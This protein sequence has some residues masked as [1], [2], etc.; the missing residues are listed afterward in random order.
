MKCQLIFYE[1]YIPVKKLECH[2][3]QILLGVF[4]EVGGPDIQASIFGSP[5]AFLGVHDPQ[6]SKMH[7]FSKCSG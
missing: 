1:K 5:I 6:T 7:I 4:E 2:L 3:L